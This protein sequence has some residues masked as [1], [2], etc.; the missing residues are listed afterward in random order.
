VI[1]RVSVF[2]VLQ[3]LGAMGKLLHRFLELRLACKVDHRA[4]LDR[5]R[6][7]LDRYNGM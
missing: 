1:P 6:H 2:L 5:I 4:G 7:I 3:H